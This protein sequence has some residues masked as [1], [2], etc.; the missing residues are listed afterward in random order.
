[1]TSSERAQEDTTCPDRLAMGGS[2][3][4]LV[5]AT[6]CVRE[7]FRAVGVRE[8]AAHDAPY[9]ALGGASFVRR[10]GWPRSGAKGPP[11]T[12]FFLQNLLPVAVFTGVILAERQ[13]S[14]HR[15]RSLDAT[16]ARGWGA[17]ALLLMAMVV[18]RRVGRR[19][20][21]WRS[22]PPSRC[23]PSRPETSVLCAIPTLIRSVP[24]PQNRCFQAQPKPRASCAARMRFPF[25][26]S[27]RSA[28]DPPR[29]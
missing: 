2:L 5:L 19:Q 27:P 8:R 13:G 16:G 7:Q 29:S 14:Q 21:G 9:D 20:A 15:M 6:C 23:A 3:S 22:K 28:P 4:V 25:R 26:P 11:N 24:R 1:M 12:K 10:T 17:W 18:R